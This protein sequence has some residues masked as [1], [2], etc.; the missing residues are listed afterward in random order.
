MSDDSAFPSK[1]TPAA[2]APGDDYPQAGLERMIMPNPIAVIGADQPDVEKALLARMGPGHVFMMGDNPA[3][4]RMPKRPKL[5]D[6]FRLRFGDITCTHLLTS[7]KRALD[8][9]H[10]EKVVIACL[11]HDIANGCL[12]RADHGYWG[13][14]LIRPYVDEEV[15]W[16]VEKHQALRYF[17]DESVGYAY[18][19]SYV[20]FF[21]PNYEPPDYIRQE[22]EA[23]RT[24]RWY[25]SSRLITLYDI[26]FFDKAE[27]IDPE[28][29]EDL[30]GR[31]FRQP[32]EGLGFDGS[33]T[34]HMWRTMIWPNN[35]L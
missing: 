35:F 33:P 9:G 18:P 1:N 30:I 2:A 32:E 6:F 26:Y 23:A 21:G 29:F 16:A 15:A 3:L 5:L 12:I 7:A 4:P 20:R 8:D 25:M 22:A 17:A 27:P 11:L 10:E 28:M 14:Q 31:N 13:A 19:E 34:A 24:H